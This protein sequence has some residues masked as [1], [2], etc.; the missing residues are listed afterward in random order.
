MRRDLPTGGQV[1][2]DYGF[3]RLDGSRVN[4][5][6]LFTTDRQT[7]ALY[8]L[9]YRPEAESP[10][11]MCS[12]MLDGL[13]GQAQHLA[14]HIDFA[15][16]AAATPAQLQALAEAREWTDLTL[17]SAQGTS[18]QSDYLAEAPDGSQLPMMNVFTRSGGA[19]HHFWGSEVFYADVEGHPRHVDQL[20]PL[21][22]VL[23]L[24]PQG[25]GESWF[26]ALSYS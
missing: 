1:A 19:V 23:D 20:W 21:W 15:V 9:M 13:A 14:Q 25:R 10:C 11:S 16:V 24:T 6:E 5:S 18:Y 4:M 8:S 26:P 17:L 3:T 12:S 7:L 22:N 2:Q